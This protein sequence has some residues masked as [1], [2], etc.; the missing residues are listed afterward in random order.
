MPVAGMIFWAIIGVVSYYIEPNQ[1]SM[2]VLVGSGM[3]FPFGIMI[4]RLTGKK[5]KISQTGNPVLRLFMQSL[6]LVVLVWP[7][8]IIAANAAQNP[9]IVVLGGAIL[10][11]IIW[12]PFG[13]ASD[14]PV[15]LEHAIGRAAASYAAYLLAPEPHRAAAIS[16]AVLLSYAYAL[17]RMRRD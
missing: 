16:A 10:M 11:G 4:D 8:V 1:L 3:I 14:D 13:W 15:G 12:I 7:L 9:D 5:L 2:V 17:I 6:G